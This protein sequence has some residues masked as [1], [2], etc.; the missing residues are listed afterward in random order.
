MTIKNP[1]WSQTPRPVIINN[2]KNFKPGT[3]LDLGGSDGINDLFLAEKGFEVTNVDIDKIALE[4]MRKEA[5]LNNLKVETINSDLKDFHIDKNYDNVITLFVLHFLEKSTAI[6]IIK[7]IQGNTTVGG[8]NIIVTFT[9]NGEFTMNPN[10]FY[11][12]PEELPD[13]YKDW[14]IL[15]KNIFMAGTKSG[16]NHER[17]I[18]VARK[19]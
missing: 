2:I 10:N 18:L 16:K 14:E 19:T 1:K 13:L 8:L 17:I 11:P 6:R 7:E 9:N 3:I 15:N 12:T 4:I 5:K